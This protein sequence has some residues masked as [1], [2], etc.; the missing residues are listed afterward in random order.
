MRAL[1]VTTKQRVPLAPDI[2]TIHEAGVPGYEKAGWFGLFAPSA[3]PQPILDRVYQAA[4]KALKDPKIVST[5]AAEGS[6]VVGNSPAEFTEFVHSEIKEW[7][8]RIRDM[9]LVKPGK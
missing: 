8:R 9:K 5:L 6:I 2:P 1:G 7:T 4:S 3:V